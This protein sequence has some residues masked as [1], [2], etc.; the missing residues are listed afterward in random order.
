[1]LVDILFAIALACEA[2]EVSWEVQMLLK[3]QFIFLSFAFV[4]FKPLEHYN[5]VVHSLLLT[6]ST[7]RCIRCLYGAFS[8]LDLT[9]DR[10]VSV[11]LNGSDNRKLSFSKLAIHRNYVI[12]K[13]L[14]LVREFTN[15]VNIFMYPAGED[16]LECDWLHSLKYQLNFVFQDKIFL[17]FQ[18]SVT[19]YVAMLYRQH[20]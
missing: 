5:K 16:G 4:L 9:V 8:K 20:V 11:V 2:F 10:Y 14:V 13:V 7:L 17:L 6:C 1:M 12:L 19:L 15:L 3:A 18:K